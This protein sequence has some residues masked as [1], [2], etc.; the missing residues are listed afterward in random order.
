LLQKKE[1]SK[2]Y[3][4]YFHVNR[5]DI[6]RCF[7]GVQQSAQ[8]AQGFHIKHGSKCCKTLEMNTLSTCVRVVLIQTYPEC[9]ASECAMATSIPPYTIN[10]GLKILYAD[11]RRY[12]GLDIRLCH[13]MSI[14]ATTREEFP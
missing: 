12:F 2:Y 3:I 5:Q 11:V 1:S 14:L 7:I 9:D 8:I 4:A 6:K 13:A 10:P